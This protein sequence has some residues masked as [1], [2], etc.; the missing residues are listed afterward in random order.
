M[1]PSYI[2]RTKNIRETNSKPLLHEITVYCESDNIKLIE[3]GV[4]G[5]GASYYEVSAALDKPIS[6]WCQ[7]GKKVLSICE[8]CAFILRVIFKLSNNLIPIETY[9]ITSQDIEVFKSKFEEKN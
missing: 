2:I 3:F 4:Y 8:H 1:R 5:H 9:K 7:E 6:C